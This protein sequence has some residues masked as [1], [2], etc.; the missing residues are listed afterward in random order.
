MQC[1]AFVRVPL[2]PQSIVPLEGGLP[3]K[4]IRIARRK[5]P[6]RAQRLE[7]S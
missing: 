7:V 6:R 3:V 5:L 4:G 1:A 2:L